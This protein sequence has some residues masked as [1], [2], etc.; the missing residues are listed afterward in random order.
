MIDEMYSKPAN[1]KETTVQKD[2]LKIKGRGSNNILIENNSSLVNLPSF[3]YVT[4]VEND[5][6]KSKKRI[7]SLESILN[8]MLIEHNKLKNEVNSLKQILNRN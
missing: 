4:F 2:Q 1:L 8:R 3:E 6:K 5:L 7:K